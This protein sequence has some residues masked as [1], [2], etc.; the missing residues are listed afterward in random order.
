[1]SLHRFR[2]LVAAVA[3]AVPV[4]FASGAEAKTFVIPHIIESLS[5][6]SSTFDTFL[7]FV[8]SGGL[9]GIVASGDAVVEVFLFA[10]DGTLLQGQTGAICDPCQFTLNASNRVARRTIESLANQH[11]GGL[12]G[13]GA[14]RLTRGYAIV[15]V[16]GAGTDEVV[17][18]AFTMNMHTS[19][20]DVTMVRLP[21][22]EIAI[23][24]S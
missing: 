17:I 5:A 16:T 8:H 18:E 2:F 14:R 12:L 19:P 23:G 13:S 11:A 20:F 15:N 10:D 24:P 21:V 22:R 4:T 1:M 3:F 7:K 9:G 6:Q